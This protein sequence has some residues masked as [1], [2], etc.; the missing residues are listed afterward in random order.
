MI[1]LRD[2]PATGQLPFGGFVPLRAPAR[3]ALVCYGIVSLVFWT[4]LVR[5]PPRY[6]VVMC[7]G[8][9]AMTLGFAFREVFITDPYSQSRFLVQNLLI[10]LSPCFFL[11]TDYMIFARLAVSLTT[12]TAPVSETCLIIPATR[13]AKLFVG[14]DITTLLIQAAGGAMLTQV[15]HASLGK[16]IVLVGLVIQLITFAAFTGI[17]AIFGLRVYVPLRCS[18]PHALFDICIFLTNQ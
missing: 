4:F 16:K 10:L 2:T 7:I 17:L 15:A 11:A 14:A 3:A 5:K 6:M 13:V 1:D 18:F 9:T 12:S 8:S